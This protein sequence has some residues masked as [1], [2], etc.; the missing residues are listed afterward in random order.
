M[1]QERISGTKEWAAFTANLDLGCEHD[2][3]YCYAKTAAMRYKR[4]TVDGWKEPRANA[5]FPKVPYK[6]GTLMFPSSHDITDRNVDRAIEFL[7]NTLEK[8]SCKILIVTK[9]HLTVIR[10]L[11]TALE[12]YK[13]RILFRFTIGSPD[14]RVL[15][16][17]EPGAPS[18]GERVACLR[19]AHTQ[20]W[21]TSVSCE[22]TLDFPEKMEELI[23]ELAPFVTDAIWIGLMNNSVTRLTMNGHKEDIP[24]L[25]KLVM[26]WTQSVVKAFY[27]KHKDNPKVKWKDSI[28]AIVGLPSNAQ[29]G[30]DQ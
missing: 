29:A 8:R 20:G 26:A 19:I 24:A 13:D 27:E 9:P 30:M 1:K 11:M 2:C 7:L 18:Y 10:K 4:T 17:W 5:K 21:K 3:K 14:E 23:A 6:D 16:F 15:K 28:K 22:P 12:K 25:D